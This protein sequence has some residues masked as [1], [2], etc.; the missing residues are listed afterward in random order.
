[1]SQNTLQ[2]IIKH[3]IEDEL[4]EF[5]S[6]EKGQYQNRFTEL[7]ENNLNQDLANICVYFHQNLNEL[8]HSINQKMKIDGDYDIHDNQKLLQLIEKF[9]ELQ[10]EC[11]AENL[12][13]MVTP[14]YQNTL[15]ECQEFLQESESS[16]IPKSL[17]TVKLIKHKPIITI[18]GTNQKVCEYINSNVRTEKAKEELAISEAVCRHIIKD[19]ARLGIYWENDLLKKDFIEPFTNFRH[20]F[21]EEWEYTGWTGPAPD[22]EILDFDEVLPKL[23]LQ[24]FLMFLCRVIHPAVRPDQKREVEKLR[25]C[26]NQRL[27]YVEYEIIAIREDSG[28]YIFEAKRID[29]KPQLSSATKAAI[30]RSD[31]KESID[32]CEKLFSQGNYEEVIINAHTLLEECACDIYRRQKGKELLDIS[33]QFEKH[34]PHFIEQC[35]GKT[36]DTATIKLNKV[37]VELYRLRHMLGKPHAKKPKAKRKPTSFEARTHLN[38]TITILDYLYSSHSNIYDNSK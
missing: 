7:Y 29:I 12:A 5:I 22:P 33:K 34:F 30:S 32:K 21:E 17:T 15:D 36:K 37:A 31:V 1:M 4:P 18:E 27:K 24:E 10:S 16:T 19:R 14:A 23:T 38:A 25:N 2:R 6:V 35:Y 13:I 28:G 9:K 3:Y 11:S 8:F 20:K 26:F